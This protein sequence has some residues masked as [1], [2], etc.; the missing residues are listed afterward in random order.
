MTNATTTTTD[1][2]IGT[3]LDG[4][5]PAPLFTPF[6]AGELTLSN[7]FVMAPMTRAF[8]PDG[9][10]GD[11]VRDYY[12]RRAAGL[13]LIV[14]EG[15][16]IDHPSAGSSDRIPLFYGDAAL[17]GWK[18]VVDAVHAE[19]GRIF[20]Q[21]WHLGVTRS[22]GAAPHPE[23]PV[24]SPSGLRSDGSAKG[25]AASTKDID[26][27]IA[28]FV[29]GALDAQ[30]IGFDGIELHGA[31]GYL[32]DQFLW[33]KTNRRGDRFGGSTSNRS[34]LAAEVV[35]AIRSEVGPHF[36]IDFRFSQWKGN[37]YGARI[38]STPEELDQILVPLVDA[39]V[40]MLHASTRRYWLPEF[41]DST[42]TLAGWTKHLTGLPTI[43]LGSIGV[44]A[45]FLGGD[46]ESQSTLSIAPLVELFEQGEFD[47]V[48]L[49]RSVMSDP[50][51]TGKIRTGRAADIRAYEKGHESTLY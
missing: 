47:L 21:L 1:P 17:A 33:S 50:E 13:G 10:P 12:A 2:L 8:S 11:D 49:G 22:E 40:S 3:L 14:T 35:S 46:E 31:H 45:P 51:F 48:A 29:Q 19:G 4:I 26:D 23:A 7:R 38:A 43:A 39:G 44:S 15:T 32:L 41:D 9:V 20:P 27:I 16:Y 37:D 18:R 25:E 30:R 6:T 34:Q 24:I 5:D 42:R 36:P 28:A